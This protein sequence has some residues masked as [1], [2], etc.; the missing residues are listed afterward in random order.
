MSESSKKAG[1]EEKAEIVK[2]Q[3]AEPVEVPVEGGKETV[4][5]ETERRP[6]S[7]VA[8]HQRHTRV[9]SKNHLEIAGR[10]ETGE[11]IVEEITP[12]AAKK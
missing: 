5:V 6:I 1:G 7:G 12:K 8:G 2:P 10:D 3:K 9:L 4:K 11:P